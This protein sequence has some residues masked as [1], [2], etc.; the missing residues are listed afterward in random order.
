MILG[1]KR[2]N[3]NLLFTFVK[4]ND[5]PIDAVVDT[6]ASRSLVSSKLVSSLSAKTL[7]CTPVAIQFGNGMV[8]N[9]NVQ[10]NGKIGFQGNSTQLCVLISNQL[11]TT[12]LLG[13][14]WLRAAHIEIKL[15]PEQTIIQHSML[16]SV[17]PIDNIT[18]EKF[19][20][21]RVLNSVTIDPYTARRISCFSTASDGK[22]LVEPHAQVFYKYGVRLEMC[23]VEL[24]KGRCDLIFD[25]HSASTSLVPRMLCVGKLL[26]L[27]VEE[28]TVPINLADSRSIKEPLTAAAPI[29]NTLP[30]RVD[31]LHVNSELTIS[32]QTSIRELLGKYIH[33]FAKDMTELKRSKMQEHAITLEGPQRPIR[34]PPYRLAQTRK[35]EVERQLRELLDCGLLR[36]SNSPWSFP[37]V[38]VEKKNGALRICVDYRKLNDITVRDAYP[39]PRIDVILEELAGDVV[40]SSIDLCSGYHQCPLAEASKELTAFSAPGLGLLEWQV[41]PFGLSNA[42]ATFQRGMDSVLGHLS[43][44]TTSVYLDDVV[45][46]STSVDKHLEHLE[47]MFQALDSADLRM[48]MD[49]CHFGLGELVVLGFVVNKE[50]I[51]TDDSKTLAMRE[52]PTPKS[53]RDVQSFH[54]LVSYY[55]VFVPNFA[56]IAKPLYDIFK[57][58]NKFEWT[59]EAQTAFDTLKLKMST[60][61]CLAHFDAAFP[62]RLSTD[63][64]YLGLGV[65]LALVKGKKEHPVAYYSRSINR[66]EANYSPS[67]L[68]MLAVTFGLRKC[69]PLLLGRK[70]EVVTDHHAICFLRSL[71]DPSS[72]LARWALIVAE[73]DFV[74]IYK[75]GRIHK[76][77]DCLSRFPVE[78]PI[79][80]TEEQLDFPCFLTNIQDL[81]KK[82]K[83]AQSTDEFC[84]TVRESL[85]DV[86]INQLKADYFLDSGLLYR[87]QQT[88][89]GEQILTCLP[90]S[91]IKD[92]LWTLHDSPNGGHQGVTRTWQRVKSSYFRP[93]LF[94][95]VSKY[96]SSCEKCQKRKARRKKAAGF[97]QS[98]EY[99]IECFESLCID[100]TGPLPM[101]NRGNRYIVACIDRSSRY[102]IAKAFPAVAAKEIAQFLTDEVITKH[103]IP[104]V[105]LSDRGPQFISKLIA[106]Y[107]TIMRIDHHLTASYRPQTNALIERSFGSLKDVLSMYVNATQTDWDNWLNSAIFALNTAVNE[108]TGYAPYFVVSGKM[109]KQAL[110]YCL[111]TQNAR[112]TILTAARIVRYVRRKARENS[113]AQHLRSK[114]LF[115]QK[116]KE[117]DFVVGDIVLRKRSPIIAGLTKKLMPRYEGPF[118]I[119]DRL[120]ENTF[121]LLNTAEGVQERYRFDVVHAERLE[122]FT[123]RDEFEKELNLGKLC[124][125]ESPCRLRAETDVG[126]AQKEVV[127]SESLPPHAGLDRTD[128]LSERSSS[129]ESIDFPA[130][131]SPCQL[132]LPIIPVAS[133]PIPNLVPAGPVIQSTRSSTRQR[134]APTRLS[135]DRNFKLQEG[136]SH[137]HNQEQTSSSSS[138]ELSE[139]TN[140]SENERDIAMIESEEELDL[141][142]VTDEESD[143]SEPRRSSRVSRA[144]TRLGYGTHF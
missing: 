121:Q 19:N 128:G 107:M 136:Q 10:L 52:F 98:L 57:K 29:D 22:Y 118:L 129:S 3:C 53:V 116:R 23:V 34:I 123:G 82:L 120:G 91:L 61:P 131:P 78:L 90:R 144:P 48:K 1:Q 66:H 64:S 108:S 42:P 104:R 88:E 9:I 87:R 39:L 27:E 18:D 21:L 130:P 17:L 143:D 114:A 126:Q 125:V 77:V 100:I 111:S 70:F 142:T 16:A 8:E 83:D 60:A 44:E 105:I 14:D 65:T 5:S 62:I 58:G 95:I 4:I 45:V 50:G 55:R 46:H 85:G 113:I 96:V 137:T 106:N 109:P 75:K 112:N 74:V 35:P 36:R 26:E 97:L 41:L 132:Q 138:S 25:N 81:L 69:R 133:S 102:I 139:Q 99:P 37:I 141:P 103:G 101:T 11:P 47:N 135:Y 54:G 124:T 33:L 67:E 28:E 93:G 63:A 20:K 134:Q 89:F 86:E 117:H 43:R 76:Q 110:D 119:T 6:G 7:P 122:H 92:V 94:K 140:T 115:D 73:F 2:A 80:E 79:P 127:A 72:R 71:R 15:S 38:V 84:I 56:A 49:K 51:K 40:F 68:E 13:L 59:P 30:K 24:S 31:E 12:L 32:E